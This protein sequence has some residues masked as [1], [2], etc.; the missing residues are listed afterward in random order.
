MSKFYMTRPNIHPN[1]QSRIIREDRTPTL[2]FYGTVELSGEYEVGDLE[3]DGLWFFDA[4]VEAEEAEAGALYR[5]EMR[6]AC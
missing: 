1:L 2:H 4:E 3:D 6:H 5:A